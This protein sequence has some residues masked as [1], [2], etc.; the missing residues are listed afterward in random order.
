MQQR[1]AWLW[2]ALS[3]AVVGGMP[4]TGGASHLEPSG[5]TITANTTISF[6]GDSTGVGV[7]AGTVPPALNNPV[8]ITLGAATTLTFPAAV[9]TVGISARETLTFVGEPTGVSITVE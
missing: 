6:A 3:L 5:L 9:G 4:W 2:V 1:R 7:T 8:I